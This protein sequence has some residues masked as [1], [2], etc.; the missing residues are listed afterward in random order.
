MK[1]LMGSGRTVG[2]ELCARATLM[3]F[4][5]LT[6]FSCEEPTA[7]QLP[8]DIEALGLPRV[9]YRLGNVRYDSLFDAAILPGASEQL[10]AVHKEL[11]DCK[12][13]F[14]G[15]EGSTALSRT[16]S[17]LADALALGDPPAE[18]L[19]LAEVLHQL[20][21][22]FFY[23]RGEKLEPATSLLERAIVVT[24]SLI[25]HP[26][27][28]IQKVALF[29]FAQHH[30]VL[31]GL[32]GRYSNYFQKLG[33]D[34]R[35]FASRTA[36]YIKTVLL[37]LR[38]APVL[39]SASNLSL[40]QNGL[41][42]VGFEVGCK[43]YLNTARRGIKEFPWLSTSE[44]DEYQEFVAATT[45]NVWGYYREHQLKDSMEFLLEQLVRNVT[46]Q[47]AY[48]LRDPITSLRSIQGRA[49]F[50]ESLPWR[51]LDYANATGDTTVLATAR[52]LRDSLAAYSNRKY[53]R[54]MFG[55]QRSL[56]D[57]A[58]LQGALTLAFDPDLRFPVTGSKAY[59]LVLELL[60]EP[61]MQDRQQIV[62][63]EFGRHDPD[64]KLLLD[65]MR[66]SEEHQARLEF[67]IGRSLEPD[68]LRRL[69]MLQEH[70]RRMSARVNQYR[71]GH[72]LNPRY[73]SLTELRAALRPHEVWVAVH[74]SG[75]RTFL[76]VCSKENF[77]LDY[78]A[79]DP[80]GEP[81]TRAAR[82]SFLMAG[83]V[84][85]GAWGANEE[86]ALEELSR[87]VLGSYLPP[88]T[89]HVI[90]CVSDRH[91]LI[92]DLLATMSNDGA[93]RSVRFDPVFHMNEGR[94]VAE[95][96]KDIRFF[97]VAPMFGASAS[98]AD[99]ATNTDIQ[100][101]IKRM[102]GEQGSVFRDML[103]PLEHNVNEVKDISALLHGNVLVEN[104]VSE[105]VL[106]AQLPAEGT[107]LHLA[108]HAIVHNTDVD[109]S[110][111]VLAQEFN[112]DP[113]NSNDNVWR[114]GEIRASRLNASLVVLSA[115]GTSATPTFEVGFDY[116]IASAFRD[117]GCTN[118]IS[119][120]WRVEDRSTHDI[121]IDFYRQLQIGKGKAE[122]LFEA[123][124]IFRERN[125]DKGP[126]YWAP[127]VLTGDDEAL[128]S[129]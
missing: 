80:T 115:C 42:E 108:T 32:T 84:N 91:R 111:V 117:A 90:L 4:L 102:K 41:C 47:H 43:D 129:R 44:R 99:K 17:L 53:T 30:D 123:K 81:T 7:E 56:K 87:E 40:D 6:V 96:P 12:A 112:D 29:Q 100:A 77:I 62:D 101:L 16:C 13:L 124:R 68:L 63:M 14:V 3:L 69:S 33:P 88:A 122:A 1:Q 54:A 66:T 5:T 79:N 118:I 20:A 21:R 126:R 22:S 25:H 37:G 59:D 18:K 78:W 10:L 83:L 71:V 8:R 113:T 85:A 31:Q 125:P 60:K 27:T 92:M 23:Q 104:D 109:R 55:H 51:F 34:R 11:R 39:R 61:D 120:L 106:M 86:E 89:E 65:S 127:L 72:M 24:G 49:H 9:E 114:V 93:L 121:M 48:R 98:G 52:V 107:I 26:D 19:M 50:A 58:D 57:M 64:F 76:A 95:E 105:P 36:L 128:F 2:L 75:D 82:M 46:G 38:G 97:G 119:S 74:G 45:I 116:S 70:T 103:G 35:T 15:G 28:T 110:G 94:N 67:L 73:R